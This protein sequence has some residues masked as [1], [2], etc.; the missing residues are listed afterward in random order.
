MLFN[1][2][3]SSNL[4]RR[5]FLYKL[6]ALDL[7]G[8][9]LNNDN[10]ISKEDLDTIHH[11]IDLG[12]EVV[13]ATGRGY[14]SARILTG[15]INKH[16]IYICNNGNIVIDALEDKIISTKFLKPSDSKLIIEEGI[17][18]NLA[19]I[20]YVDYF[21]QN[22]DIILDKNN[23]YIDKYI[24][25]SNL[26]SRVKVVEGK[27]DENLDRI[28]A[29]VYPG[30]LDVLKDFNYSINKLYP[31]K[32]NSHVIENVTISEGFLE[33]MNPLGTK[34]N[35]LIEYASS[36]GIKAEEIIAFGDDNNDIE[37][38]MNA[39]LGIAMKNG[40]KLVK[41]VANQI[42]EKDNNNSGISFELKKLFKI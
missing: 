13:I 24:K 33:V 38:I 12:Y 39:G 6:I 32:Y 1:K 2:V 18:R 10:K 30:R 21:H 20:I 5:G 26:K 7:D 41:E 42:S 17:A 4:E 16:L 23:Y 40:G 15:N 19:P 34:W 9:L 28:L 29:L 22:Y 25:G 36:I 27:L 3:L 37:M 8:T 11:L 14:Y 31:N 35:T